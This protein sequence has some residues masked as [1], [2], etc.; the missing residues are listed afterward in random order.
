M[1]N[2]RLAVKGFIVNED[3]LLILKRASDNP[4]KPNIWEIPGGRLDLGED[5]QK[6]LIR[7]I[8][9]ETGIDVE[10]L[11]PINIR[12]FERDDGQI[13]TMLIF[14]CKSYSNEVSL[15]KEH[16]DFEWIPLSICEEKL[17]TFFHEDVNI[18]RKL[19]FYKFL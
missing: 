4:Q 3:R 8:I 5:P 15:S 13:I 19:E 14:L 2:F 11:F 6:G 12:H 10:I 7:E 18:F 1:I 9:E 16:V 17:S